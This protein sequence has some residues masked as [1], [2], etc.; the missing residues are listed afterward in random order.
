MKPWYCLQ[1]GVCKRN[2]EHNGNVRQ[3]SNARWLGALFGCWFCT[4]GGWNSL[5]GKCGKG[6]VW[7]PQCPSPLLRQTDRRMDRE[8]PC[9]MHHAHSSTSTTMC[10]KAHIHA[11]WSS[12][13]IQTRSFFLT[14]SSHRQTHTH[15]GTACTHSFDWLAFFCGWQM[16]DWSNYPSEWRALDAEW[17]AVAA[18]RC[19]SQR[20][21][22]L[23]GIILH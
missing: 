7:G 18:S 5:A 22:V 8:R 16:Y 4:P 21:R 12:D 19:S 14:F 6:P 11:P 2:R 15:T 10:M 23:M 13:T 1:V 20:Y 9:M 3:M 17:A